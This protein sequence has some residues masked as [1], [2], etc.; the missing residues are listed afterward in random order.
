MRYFL[1]NDEEKQGPYDEEEIRG[2]LE[3]RA[4]PPTVLAAAEEGAGDWA[5]THLPTLIGPAKPVLAVTKPYFLLENG[6][7]RGPFTL[8]QLR[9]MWGTGTITI[10][11]MHCQ[12]GDGHW[13]PLSSSLHLLEPPP[14]V[15]PADAA[16]SQPKV[17]IVRAT[18]S[19]GVYIILGLFFGL[20]GI[21]NFYAGHNG[22]GAAQLIITLLLGWLFIGVV[23]TFL[24]SLVEI[25][26]ETQDGDGQRMT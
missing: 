1:W 20:L 23:I 2:L 22:R 25:I 10:N 18:K 5:P 8:G 13:R 15:A 14:A 12:E 7:S 6:N 11:T 3:R 4:V 24:W 16:Y 21:H 19:R 9:S 26:S 17:L